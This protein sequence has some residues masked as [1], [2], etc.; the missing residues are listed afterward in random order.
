M[1]EDIL[2]YFWNSNYEVKLQ[3]LLFRL[4]LKNKGYFYF[5]I[6]STGGQTIFNDKLIC[7]K[8][9]CKAGRGGGQGAH[10]L[11]WRSEFESCWSLQFF[12]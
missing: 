12:V 5:S 3:W 2:G 6:W 4:F 8:Q 7:N 1:Y 9:W 11:L 10:L